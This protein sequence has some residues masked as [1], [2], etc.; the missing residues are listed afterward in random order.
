[1]NSNLSVLNGL[2]YRQSSWV[3]RADDPRMLVKMARSFVIH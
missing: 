3:V 2:V 1:M